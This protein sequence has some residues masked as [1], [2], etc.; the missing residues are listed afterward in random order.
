MDR[1]QANLTDHAHFDK[2][3]DRANVDIDARNF[4]ISVEKEIIREHIRDAYTGDLI[5]DVGGNWGEVLSGLPPQDTER[6]MVIDYAMNSLAIG[7]QSMT[8][9]EYVAGNAFDLPLDDETAE[10]VVCSEVIE[11]VEDAQGLINELARVV[12]PG[13]TLVL[14][15]PSNNLLKNAVVAAQTH[16]HD[17]PQYL[18]QTDHPEDYNDLGGI[19]HLGFPREELR[20]MFT[21]A[22]LIPNAISYTLYRG[23]G[24]RFGYETA[25]QVSNLLSKPI[26]RQV[27]SGHF[28]ASAIKR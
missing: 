8:D 16:L 10:I 12:R 6:A 1:G 21:E 27:F 15:G 24:S 19:F 20:G 28:I 2:I 23:C 3:A 7:Y 9:V 13:G 26:L 17:D 22:G 4:I 11:H 14:S 25:E 5:I 18:F